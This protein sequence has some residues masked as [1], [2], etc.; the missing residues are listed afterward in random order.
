MSLIRYSMVV[1]Y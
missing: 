1:L